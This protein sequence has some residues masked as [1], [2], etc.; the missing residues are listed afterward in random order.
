MY[1]AVI[2]LCQNAIELLLKAS[3]LVKGQPLPRTHGGCIHKFGELYVVSGLVERDVISRLYRA[4][5]LR[6]RSRY[7]PD[8]TP[9]EAEANEV[10]QLYRDL[11]KIVERLIGL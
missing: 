4:L 3:I 6:N 7:D 8:Y 10:L 1:R 5:E 9:T 2:D 11:R